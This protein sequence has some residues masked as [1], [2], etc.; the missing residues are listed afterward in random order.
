[1]TDAWAESLIKMTLGG[2]RL[3][4]CIGKGGF[5]YVFE[6]VAV[7]TGTSFA[8]KVLSPSKAFDAEALLD[9]D[10]EGALLAKLN[11]C[12]SVI[13]FVDSGSETIPVM[14]AES[15]A[16]VPLPLK[17]HVLA[18]ASGSLDE[19]L[20]SPE[21]RDELAWPARIGL[22]RGAI[23]GVH[24][25]HLK[26]VA[27]RDLKSSNCL[28][29]VAGGRSEVRLADLGRSKDYARAPRHPADVYLSGRGD[30][31]HA[32]PEFL[33]LQGGS[34]REDFRNADIYGLG[35]LLAELATGQPMTALAMASWSDVQKLGVE[36]Y[37][38]GRIR[39]LATL[40]PQFQS[41]IDLISETFPQP[42]R[43]PAADLLSQLCDPV[44]SDRRPQRS[45]GK[46]YHPD[47]GL[48]WL[49]RRADILSRQL[50][51]A[52]RRRRMM[53]RSDERSA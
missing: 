3:E 24:Q 16:P 9:F 23:K 35:S 43:R 19:L 25:M 10:N 15:A 18:L 36:D 30:L 8:M 29:I 17:F 42:I 6:V 12:S 20:A 28:L 26:S 47:D 5:G 14:L 44:P 48:L 2:Y 40:R 22:W 4:R 11:R 38:A 51:V 32:P 31:R 37:R 21:T 41:A 27:H 39:D 49:L 33:L 46:R 45:L 52:P 7:D 53:S 1:M 13:N 34:A 50:A